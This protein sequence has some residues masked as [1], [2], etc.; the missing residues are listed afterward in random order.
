MRRKNSS[1]ESFGRKLYR[2]A[3]VEATKCLHCKDLQVTKTFR[4]KKLYST[5]RAV[6]EILGPYARLQRRLLKS[7]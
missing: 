4:L 3:N 6:S 2:C 5:N 7:I 1:R